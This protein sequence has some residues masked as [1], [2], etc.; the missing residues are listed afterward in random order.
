MITVK[1]IVLT[2]EEA[3]REVDRLNGL[4]RN[5]Q[6]TYFWQLTRL[7]SDSPSREHR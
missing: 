5:K 4:N 3:Q 6:S 7:V 2:K 1:E